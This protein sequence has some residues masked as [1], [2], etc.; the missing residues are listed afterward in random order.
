MGAPRGLALPGPA[1]RGARR[2]SPG[3][4]CLV[5]L[6]A[7]FQCAAA[8]CPGLEASFVSPPPAHS[9]YSAGPAHVLDVSVTYAVSWPLDEDGEAAPREGARV[10]DGSPACEELCKHEHAAVVLYENGLN[11]GPVSYA[12]FGEHAFMLHRPAGYYNLSLRWEGAGGGLVCAEAATELL[13]IARRL[14]LVQAPWG[15]QAGERLAVQ[16]S[17]MLLLL[18][19]AAPGA[20]FALDD[21]AGAT[22]VARLLSAGPTEAQTPAPRAALLADPPRAA[23]DGSEG[24]EGAA[25]AGSE[26]GRA[27]CEAVPWRAGGG[28][29][30]AEAPAGCVARFAGLQ[31]PSG[32]RAGLRVVL[33]ELHFEGQGAQGQ[34]QGRAQGQGVPAA[35]ADLL[36]GPATAGRAGGAAAAEQIISVNGA[37]WTPGP[38]AQFACCAVSWIVL[39]QA[40]VQVV[41]AVVFVTTQEIHDGK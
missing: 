9:L 23:T 35:A 22:V 2:G 27:R 16:P 7:W 37:L 18:A 34:G 15:A 14:E 12:E 19:P 17:V 33:F 39:L 40:T 3:A 21:H 13:I 32:A 30:A 24:A 26:L 6:L 4:L 20:R 10:D 36:V 8:P 1:N 5:L 41:D 25:D 28:G 38:F 31:V 11:R 29:D